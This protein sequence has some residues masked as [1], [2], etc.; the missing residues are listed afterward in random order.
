[1]SRVVPSFVFA[2]TRSSCSI[3]SSSARP[4]VLN[5]IFQNKIKAGNV[6]MQNMEVFFHYLVLVL[7][8]YLLRTSKI[9]SKLLHN[10]VKLSPECQFYHWQIL[11]FNVDSTLWMARLW[12]ITCFSQPVKETY[13]SCKISNIFW[14]MEVLLQACSTT[15]FSVWAMDLIWLLNLAHMCHWPPCGIPDISLPKS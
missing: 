8:Y 1:M 6:V 7:F 9:V 5:T 12:A 3:W 11:S 4:F 2:I 10:S 14:T 13:S 15:K